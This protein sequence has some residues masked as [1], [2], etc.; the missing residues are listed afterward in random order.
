MIGQTVQVLYKEKNNKY[1]VY[2]VFATDDNKVNISTTANNLESVS[3]EDKI[4]VDG[5][6]Y[7]VNYKGGAGNDEL[8][9]YIVKASGT[10]TAVVDSGYAVKDDATLKTAIDIL[11]DNGVDVQV[12][13]N[14][15][16]SK[17]DMIIVFD[18]TFA[19]LT[20][21]NSSIWKMIP[22]LSTTT[23]PRTTMSLYRQTFTTTLLSLKR[24][25]L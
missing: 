20:A 24:L 13:S 11:D 5:T 10:S 4:K 7:T 16:D 15:G 1:T 22:R 6:N 9:I 14:D 25:K 3:G 2:G 21:A 8:P 19:K 23:M 17:I 18:K 12:I